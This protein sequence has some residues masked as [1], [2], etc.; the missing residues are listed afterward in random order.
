MSWIS[1]SVRSSA[2]DR[3]RSSSGM[4]VALG[5]GVL[6]IERIEDALSVPE[7]ADGRLGRSWIL[8]QSLRPVLVI[9]ADG[10][11]VS[12]LLGRIKRARVDDAGTGRNLAR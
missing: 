3:S 1:C 12:R 5:G 11:V 9:V 8:I 2:A 6:A 4:T 7:R 10:L